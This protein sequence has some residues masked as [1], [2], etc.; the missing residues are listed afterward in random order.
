MSLHPV[1]Y[2]N[3]IELADRWQVS[4][5][6]IRKWRLT[7]GGPRFRKFGTAVRYAVI[8]VEA[9]EEAAARTSTSDPGVM[10]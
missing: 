4:V 7:G 5:R 10:A 6:T 1:V 2:L 8:D 3:E 9:F